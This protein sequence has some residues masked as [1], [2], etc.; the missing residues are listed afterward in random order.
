[1]NFTE[2]MT[3]K[4]IQDLSDR[5]KTSS[6]AITTR[7]MLA[8]LLVEENAT[9]G[10]LLRLTHYK[11]SVA[12][13]LRKKYIL[14]GFEAIK[15]KKKEKKSKSFLTRNQ[16]QEITT[17]LNEKVPSDI[18]EKA[19]NCWTTWHL[20]EFIKEKYDVVYK[21]KTS[22]YLIF[23]STKFSFRKPQKFSVR[24]NDAEIAAWKEQYKPIFKIECANQNNV[25]LVGD[26]VIL[27][28]QTRLQKAWLPAP[29]K[30]GYIKDVT[31][32]KNTSLYGFLD[33]QTGEETAY[34]SE[35]QNSKSTIIV[36]NKLAE[37][38]KNKRIVLFWDNA[39]WHRSEEIKSFLKTTTQFKL[40]SFPPYAPDLN[41]QEHVWKEMKEKI[42]GNK[43]IGNFKET[44]AQALL[45]L[46]TTK[47]Q[48]EFLDIK[49]S[50]NV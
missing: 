9:E 50:R 24:R 41:P 17:V 49:P 46:N 33:V 38:Y 26:E 18:W 30:A 35:K 5:L 29:D 44:F 12:V 20:A 10:S 47:F 43:F 37:K 19:P 6:S 4:Q 40:Y 42:F 14:G 8:I 7:R 22:L 36:L 21:S 28:S 2:K 16:K 27:T 48:Y 31:N 3:E 32:R 39:S 1:M 25:V 15:S 23:K 11:R 45:F 13:K 34:H